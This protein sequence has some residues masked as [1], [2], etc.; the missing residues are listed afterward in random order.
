MDQKKN[1]ISV[2]EIY[3]MET[4]KRKV[5]QEFS[6][7]IEAPNWTP[8]GQFLVYNSGGF[9]YT[10]DLAS[11]VSTKIYTGVCTKCNN[12]HVLSA[13]GKYLAVSAG[14]DDIEHSRIWVLPFKGGEPKLITNNMPSYLHGWS[15]DGTTLAYCADRNDNYDIYTIDLKKPL[16]EVRLT[17]APGLNDGPEYS[18]DGNYIWFNS[19][20]TG[21]MQVWRMKAD[22]TEQMQMT[23]DEDLNTWFPHLSPDNRKVVCISYHEGDVNP[24]DHPA[25]KMS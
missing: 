18:P 23:F 21:L 22:G 9:V 16:K 13:D 20:R 12:D 8:D 2:L 19:V 17:T 14:T 7:H 1:I 11:G 24:G 15:P 4:R 10:Y 25:N 5:L 6:E 3:D